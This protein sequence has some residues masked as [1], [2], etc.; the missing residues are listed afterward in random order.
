MLTRQTRTGCWW[1]I[2]SARC[3][4]IGA[5]KT[6]ATGAFPRRYNILW[7]IASPGVRCPPSSARGTASG[8]GSRGCPARGRS[9]HSSRHWLRAAEPP[10]RSRC[11]T[12]PRFART[13]RRPAQKGAAKSGTWTFPQRIRDEN[14]P[15]VRSRRPAAR[16]PPDQE[17]SQFETLP[18]IGPDIVPRCVIAPVIPY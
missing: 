7:S 5:T 13:F 10:E 1:W 12:A 17:P 14:P 6:A 8:S 4:P 2:S 18:E 3:V 9:W 11:S 16:L 15:P